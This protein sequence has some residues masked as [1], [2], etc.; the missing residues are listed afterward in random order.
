MV[1]R[2]SKAARNINMYYRAVGKNNSE[3]VDNLK[4]LF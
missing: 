1:K 2:F 4:G 3:F